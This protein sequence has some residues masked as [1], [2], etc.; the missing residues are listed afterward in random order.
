MAEDSA[1]LV[2]LAQLI[3]SV[4]YDIIA[5]VCAGVPFLVTLLWSQKDKVAKLAL[6]PWVGFLLLLG[7]GY[8]T[9]LVLTSGSLLWD[10]LALQRWSRNDEIAAVDKDA[11]AVLAKMAAEAA[12][13]QNLLTAFVV[14]LIVNPRVFVDHVAGYR[15]AICLSLLVAAVYRTV[16]YIRRQS[17]LYEIHVLRKKVR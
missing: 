11:G 3:P 2:S 14:L 10:V 5:R 17:S 9:G 7:A 13:C 6:S 15:W 4:Y 12:L 8:L 1:P 16:V